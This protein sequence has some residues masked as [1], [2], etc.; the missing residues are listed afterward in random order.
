MILGNVPS[1]RY[2]LLD[3]GFHGHKS[4]YTSSKDPIDDAGVDAIAKKLNL[5]H[6]NFY[7]ALYVSRQALQAR[8]KKLIPRQGP[9][10][11]PQR[12][13]EAD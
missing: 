1:L 13:V 4:D 6:W 11:H 3:A 5:G 8:T 7:G 2:V 12:A 9:G 10:S